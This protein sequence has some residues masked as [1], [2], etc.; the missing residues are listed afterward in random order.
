MASRVTLV[1]VASLTLSA[2]G[3]KSQDETGDQSTQSSKETHQEA[4]SGSC[5]VTKPNGYTP[6]GETPNAN[7]HGDERLAT[8]LY[9]PALQASARNTHGDSVTD[10]FGW[11]RGVAGELR[12]TGYRLDDPSIVL[13]ADV[14][15]GYG[16]SGFQVA[17]VTFPTFGCWRVVAA[18]KDASLES[19]IRVGPSR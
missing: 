8:V 14:P 12:V 19:V 4:S 18:V 1:L 2:C 5:P 16:D 3:A 17:S 9:Y 7:Y 15:S 6:A 10:K 11:W 13:S